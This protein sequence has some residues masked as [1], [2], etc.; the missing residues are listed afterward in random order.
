MRW[1]PSLP[2]PLLIPIALFVF[3]LLF[4]PAT[5]SLFHLF[6]IRG[7]LWCIAEMFFIAPDSPM[8]SNANFF[9]M[10]F[11]YAVLTSL[12]L[13]IHC[14]NFPSLPF[15]SFPFLFCSSPSLLT[16]PE[17]AFSVHIYS[18]APP[19]GFK[20]PRPPYWFSL[21]PLISGVRYSSDRVSL[22]T[23]TLLKDFLFLFVAFE[24]GAK[25]KFSHP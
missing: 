14:V 5:H 18:L 24:V 21:A 11:H 22:K 1:I 25:C 13:I 10:E 4:L 20:A 17:S 16:Q 23:P 9:I 19:A 15:L 3:Y 2:P 7:S 8:P 12:A 6:T